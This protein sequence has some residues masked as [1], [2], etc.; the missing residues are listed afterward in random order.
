MPRSKRFIPGD[1]EEGAT[2]E[3]LRIEREALSKGKPH[4]LKTPN[5]KGEVSRNL[6]RSTLGKANYTGPGYQGPDEVDGCKQL[7]LT[8][9]PQPAPAAAQTR[10]ESTRKKSR[11]KKAG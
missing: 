2:S 7:D 1:P 4:W 10:E 6:R 11:R 9:E 3:Q 5:F 8:A